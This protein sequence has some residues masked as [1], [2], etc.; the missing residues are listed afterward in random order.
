M[1]IPRI[2]YVHGHHRVRRA[3]LRR[4]AL[5]APYGVLFLFHV[6]QN[7]QSLIVEPYFRIFGEID[8][9]QFL[10]HR[11]RRRGIRYRSARIR[12]RHEQGTQKIPQTDLGIRRARACVR[13]RRAVLPPVRGQDRVLRS[14]G[15]TRNVFLVLLFLFHGRF[16]ESG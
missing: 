15:N 2:L 9:E 10:G 4:Y 12:S 14:D 16:Q 8:E 5:F 7:E 13:A 1:G 6:L 3:L 11:S